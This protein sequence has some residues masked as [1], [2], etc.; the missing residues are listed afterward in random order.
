MKWAVLRKRYAWRVNVGTNDYP[1]E[2][3]Y[4][5]LSGGLGK[6]IGVHQARL[7]PSVSVC[8]FDSEWANLG[9]YFFFVTSL[10]GIPIAL[11]TPLP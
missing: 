7:E 1:F 8:P 5:D 4:N 11:A 6:R 10:S 2:K 3:E 9:T